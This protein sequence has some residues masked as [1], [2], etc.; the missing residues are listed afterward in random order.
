M[1]DI[2]K[3]KKQLNAIAK[4]HKMAQQEQQIAMQHA[5]QLMMQKGQIE[6]DIEAL[7]QEIVEVSQQATAKDIHFY[8]SSV[9]YLDDKAEQ[10]ELQNAALETVKKEIV[11]HN[12]TLHYLVQKE[13][14]LQVKMDNTTQSIATLLKQKSNRQFNSYIAAKT[15]KEAAQLSKGHN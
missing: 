3:V 14:R 9:V 15:T 1:E 5:G 6:R 7:E 8:L 10:L 12:Q 13:S 11:A 4:L 2:N